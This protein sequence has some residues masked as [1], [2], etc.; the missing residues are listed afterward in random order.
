MP[1]I[2]YCCCGLLR[3]ETT[4]EPAIVAACHCSECQRRTG[5]PFGVGCYFES[6][7]EPK[8]PARSTLAKSRKAGSSGSISAQNA[9]PRSIGTWICD[10]TILASL[11]VHSL[12]RPSPRRRDQSGRN[13]GIRGSPSG[14]ISRTSHKRH[15][16]PGP[17]ADPRTARPALVRSG[18]LVQTGPGPHG[19]WRSSKGGRSV[20]DGRPLVLQSHRRCVGEEPG[21]GGS[22]V[23]HRVR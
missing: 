17:L 18:R 11:S 6:R 12:I 22:H 9:A 2:A 14:T 5:A 23:E 20:C 1:R 3:V 4:G 21:P 15:Q 10:P 13:P 19:N 16:P 7:F 8:E